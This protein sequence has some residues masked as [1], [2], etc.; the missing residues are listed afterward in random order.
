MSYAVGSLVKARGR[1]WVVLPEST[2]D[3]LV[4]RPLGGSE[5]ETTGIYVPLE[6]VEPA[7]LGLPSPDKVGD[8][9]SCR[10]LRDA[11]RL[12][13]RSSAGPFRSFGRI[14]VEPRPYQLVPLLMAL[15]LDPVRLLIADDVGI[16]KT[17]EALLIARELLD[18]GEISRLAVLCP[19]HLA[20]QWQAELVE[21]FHIDAELVLP[22]TVTKLERNCGLGQ[23]LFDIYP[24]VVV[25][26]DFI[27]SER[28]RSEFL[29]VCPEFVIVDEAHTCAYDPNT[30]GGR[31]Q[32]YT[33][34]KDLAANP[35]RHMVLVT[36]TPHS[37]NEN[38]FRSLLSIL[39]EEF[40]ELP[41]D[42]SG[43]ENEGHRRKLAAHF[44]QRRRA[45]IRYYM[46]AETPFPAREDAE[47]SYRL[48]PR[49]KKFFDKVVDYARETVAV[50]GESRHHQRIRWWSAL[51]L[52]RALASSPAAAA[53]T[54]R[55][56]AGVVD[57]ETPEEAD[58]LGRKTVLDL[59]I[60]E[61][62]DVVDVAPGGDIGEVA[63][64]HDANRRRLLEMAREAESLRGEEDAKLLK[65]VELLRSLVDDGYHPIVFCRFIETA[66]Y[67]AEELRRRLS[68]VE[69]LAVTG[70]LTP[71][72]REERVKDLAKADKRILVAT[73]CLSEGINLQES[74]DS[75]VHY[76][77]SWNPTRHEQR[78]G[79]VDRYGQAKEKVRVLTYYGLD[80]YID[81]IVL[82]VLLRKHVKIRN[83]LGISVP[84][85]ANTDAVV[86]AIFES[87]LI[88]RG[89]V[90]SQ[91]VQLSLF[92]DD[93]AVNNLHL[94]W[95]NAASREKRS[96]TLFAQ[97]SI[98]VDEVQR[99]I[100]E[101]RRAIGSPADLARFVRDAV[102]VSGGAAQGGGPGKPMRIDLSECPAALRDAVG[103]AVAGAGGS[104]RGWGSS[105][106]RAGGKL[107]F[108]AVFEL[109]APDGALYLTRTH[110][111]VEGLASFIAEQAL[112]SQ[113]VPGAARC[114]AIRT[115][116]VAKRTTLLILRLRYHIEYV[117]QGE[118]KPLLAEEVRLAAF[119]GSPQ[120][121]V[122]LSDEAAEALLAVEAEEN[123]GPDQARI[124]VTRVIEG[125]SALV[126]HIEELAAQRAQALL[127]AHTRV[128]T[129]SKQAGRHRVRPQLP[130][131][132]VGIYVYLPRT[133]G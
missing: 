85:P 103:A 35:D 72:E 114:G 78:E 113:E 34:V 31:H 25:S 60:E 22:G 83:S 42:L 79:R 40:A 41:E 133:Q 26:T 46:K 30:R 84:V 74:F 56:R 55:T 104:P 90:S 33:L 52:L 59:S 66:E 32:R 7:E 125:Y 49:Y 45:D 4:L 112:E 51:A 131:D 1:E 119:E 70:R 2:D 95:E 53:A 17:V 110:P 120:N 39:K 54:L 44:V 106:A 43:P 123:I 82:D 127:E 87:L 19:P 89:A 80:N 132:V 21:K 5:A 57:T 65:A 126:P 63:L 69:T 58:E 24:F 29:R 73:D 129:A 94:A 109:P 8:H 36:A 115:S 62:M 118:T 11:V 9:R 75:V 15:K 81:G 88:R 67:L 16:G 50:P 121:A 38:A 12:G 124:F 10:L 76:D 61:S 100:E 105:R 91:G 96:R 108:D 128:R 13:F 27:K 93:R 47:E 99:E 97:E 71:A 101:M 92:K 68:D 6:P 117:R 102:R 98:K 20:E 3:F 130:V 107:Q 111:V 64:D 48:T 14:A 86:E 77:L 28:R 18:R 122:W 23:S 37:G 116:K